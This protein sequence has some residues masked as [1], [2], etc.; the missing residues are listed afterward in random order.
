MNFFEI[1]GLGCAIVLAF[2]FMY[3][4]NEWRH[5]KNIKM[6]FVVSCVFMIAMSWSS[7]FVV[8]WVLVMNMLE[9]FKLDD[10]VVINGKQ[11]IDH[12]GSQD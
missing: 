12:H 3:A 8:L 1:Y 4:L 5:G 6:S 9:K 11:K 7:V 2:V 10:I